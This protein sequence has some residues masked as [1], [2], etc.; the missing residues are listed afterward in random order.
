MHSSIKLWN[1]EGFLK[2]FLSSQKEIVCLQLLT[3]STFFCRKKIGMENLFPE[4]SMLY[5][6]VSFAWPK[7]LSLEVKIEDRVIWSWQ[8]HSWTLFSTFDWLTSALYKNKNDLWKEIFPFSGKN[9]WPFLFVKLV[10]GLPSLTKWR[11]IFKNEPISASFLYLSF[12]HSVH[13]SKWINALHILPM[14]GFKPGSSGVW[15][16]RSVNFATTTVQVK[17]IKK[18]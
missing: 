7:F 6:D 13:K 15:S 3:D 14:T 4:Q 5:C 12:P 18:C 8:G 9:L 1:E 2:H 11:Y 16:D 17:N 10:V